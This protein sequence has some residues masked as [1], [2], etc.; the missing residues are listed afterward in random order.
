MQETVTKEP[1]ASISVVIPCYRCAAT[2]GRAVASV[3]RQSVRPAEVILV[4]DASGDDTLSVLRELALSYSGWVRIVSLES[5]QG[6]ASARNAGWDAA[7]Q[8]YIAFLDADDEWH[9]EKLRIQYEYMC[10][11]PRVAL[12]GHHCFWPGGAGPFEL[13]AQPAVTEITP[14]SLV[15]RNRFSTP[16]VML[17]RDIP[18]RF[19]AGKRYSE[20]L[21][22]WQ[23]VAFSGMPVMRLE[24]RLAY[25]H[26]APY[27]AS[28]LSARL[29]EMEKGELENL[30]DLYRTGEIKSALFA[31]AAIFSVVKFAKRLL[32]TGVRALMG[33]AK[34]LSGQ[35]K[36]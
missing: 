16:T 4:D 6:A 33:L 3:N 28:G 8:P 13:A 20:D 21:N 27:G 7:T 32:L 17:R 19:P 26:K 1:R 24:C 9:P 23:R 11:N 25:L 15:F 36:G 35:G 29:W 31:M 10:N 2:I 14:V 5:N 12:S 34:G 18:Y 22:L 30:S